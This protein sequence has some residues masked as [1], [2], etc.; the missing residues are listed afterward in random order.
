MKKFLLTLL[1]L[2]FA[3]PIFAQ[4]KPNTK[5]NIN[6]TIDT[7]TTNESLT[8]IKT[9]FTEYINTKL[10]N[11][12]QKENINLIKD[13]PFENTICDSHTIGETYNCICDKND[14][15]YKNF[16]KSVTAITDFKS[17]TG[18]TINQFLQI[19]NFYDA[20]DALPIS[21]VNTF[22]DEISNLIKQNENDKAKEEAERKKY[23]TRNH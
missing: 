22:A 23:Y 4:T 12:K 16:Y 2:L 15:K 3:N 14:S 7:K 9:N 20:L 5:T 1:F 11:N 18:T 17:L 6:I 8:K 10:C 13:K 21:S 19:K